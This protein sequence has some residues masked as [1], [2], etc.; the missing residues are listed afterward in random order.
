MTQLTTVWILLYIVL[1]ISP[2][3]TDYTKH[4][5]FDGRVMQVYQTKDQCLKAVQ[6]IKSSSKDYGVCVEGYF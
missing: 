6:D 4:H 2:N 5:E 3:G 1:P